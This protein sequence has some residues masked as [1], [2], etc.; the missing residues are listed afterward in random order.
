MN[1]VFD[2]EANGLEPDKIFCIVA[3]DVD[4]RATYKYDV[5]NLED[6]YRL[7]SSADK[8]IGHNI[9]CYD[10]PVIKKIAG[11]DLTDKKIV[12]TLVLSRLFKPTREGGHGLESWG[13]RLK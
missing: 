7:L 10:M 13:Y 9:L 8:L 3:Y 12:D 5:D 11:V 2:I 1:L 6:G 4:T